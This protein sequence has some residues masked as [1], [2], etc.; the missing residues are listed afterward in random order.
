MKK[1]SGVKTKVKAKDTKGP[2][3]ASPKKK[4]KPA[5]K[6]SIAIKDKSKKPPKAPRRCKAT[7]ATKDDDT[8]DNTGDGNEEN[9]AGDNAGDGNHEYRV[10]DEGRELSDPIKA[11]KFKKMMK[12]GQ[13]PETLSRLGKNLKASEEMGCRRRKR[14]SSTVSFSEL[15]R[16]LLP[17]HPIPTSRGRLHTQRQRTKMNGARGFVGRKRK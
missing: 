10:N 11:K 3:G 12:A 13:L 7:K 16:G 14:G 2:L 4:A 8:G 6:R 1:P 5:S 15:N 9:D 17:Y